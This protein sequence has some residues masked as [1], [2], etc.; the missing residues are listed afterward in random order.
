MRDDE[1]PAHHIGADHY[2]KTI[3]DYLDK[4]EVT[5]VTVDLYVKTQSFS[6]KLR[7]WNLQLNSQPRTR[8]GLEYAGYPDPLDLLTEVESFAVKLE[9][10]DMVFLNGAH[11]HAVEQTNDEE[12]IIANF[13]MGFLNNS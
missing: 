12:R 1:V 7:V 13:F 6:G 9:P 8:L 4:C 5:A 3:S 2:G 11:I 10:G